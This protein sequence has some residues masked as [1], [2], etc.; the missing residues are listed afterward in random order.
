MTEQPNTPKPED[1]EHQAAEE[2]AR[3]LRFPSERLNHDQAK[4]EAE[5]QVIDGEAPP[6]TLGRVHGARRDVRR[7]RLP[8]VESGPVNNPRTTT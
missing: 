6:A 2:Q 5:P 1:N 8:M 4:A 3:V 7:N